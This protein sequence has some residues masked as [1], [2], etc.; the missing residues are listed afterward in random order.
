MDW[1]SFMFLNTFFCGGPHVC[2]C[3]CPQSC[4]KYTLSSK[5]VTALWPRGGLNEMNRNSRK[6]LFLDQF[7]IKS[8]NSKSVFAD[9]KMITFHRFWIS[10]KSSPGTVYWFS[11]TQKW[12]LFTVFGPVSNQVQEQYNYWSKGIQKWTLFRGASRPCSAECC[13]VYHVC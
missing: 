9:P 6:S 7:Q 3:V 8:R 12:S 10:F 4:D 13:L 5:G 2:V 1:P 11:G